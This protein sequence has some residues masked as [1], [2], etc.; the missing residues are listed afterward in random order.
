MRQLAKLPGFK[1]PEQPVPQGPLFPEEL[2]Y[3]WDQF[4]T[5]SL[6]MSVNGMTP[7]R[8]SWEVVVAWRDLTQAVIE[9]W[10]AEAIVYLGALRA[11]IQAEHL[12]SQRK[13]NAEP[14]ARSRAKA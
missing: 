11:A 10:E 7:P 13:K 5:I 8:I 3:L 14:K 4:Q 1:T 6:G 12:D 2:N 9:P